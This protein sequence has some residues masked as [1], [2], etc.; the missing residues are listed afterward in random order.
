ME[1]KIANI[2]NGKASTMFEYGHTIDSENL[3]LITPHQGYVILGQTGQGEKIT[4]LEEWDQIRATLTATIDVSNGAYTLLEDSLHLKVT[5]EER[6]L[7]PFKKNVGYLFWDCNASSTHYNEVKHIIPTIP[8]YGLVS[9]NLNGGMFTAGTVCLPYPKTDN[10]SKEINFGRNAFYKHVILRLLLSGRPVSLKFSFTLDWMRK[11]VE[12]YMAICTLECGDRKAAMELKRLEGQDKA[13][14]RNLEKV[15]KREDFTGFYNATD[16]VL[17]ITGEPV[18]IVD[19]IGKTV[20]KH[21]GIFSIGDP[22]V[23]TGENA[24]RL[25]QAAKKN[26]TVFEV[27]AG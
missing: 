6:M 5:E 3:P 23:I 26:R 1:N 21:R 19:L 2:F 24:A 18:K 4:T 12:Q 9:L 13:T 17:L 8:Q 22:L 7:N 15:E 25:A 10:D 11:E 20:Q 14:M 16:T 27:V